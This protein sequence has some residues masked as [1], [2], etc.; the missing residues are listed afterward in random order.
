MSGRISSWSARHMHALLSSAG[1][2]VRSP[3]ATILTL[4]V[5]A[6]A[7]A[8]PLGL[9]TLVQ[10]TRSATGDFSGAIGM[11]VFLKSGVAEAKAQQL[12]GSLR[13][14]GDV[15]AA[16][17]ITAE[18][19]L[20][21]FRKDSGFGAALDALEENPLPHVIAVTPV[22][23]ATPAGIESLRRYLVSWPEV[24][25]VQLDSE[26]V[27][28]FNAILAV[29]R[30]VLL[31]AATLLGIG[32]IAIVGNTIR[33]EIL[34]RRAEIEVT[35]LVGGTNAFVRRP[36]LY[37]G[38]WYGLMAG[39]TAWLIV[40]GALWGLSGPAASLA[41]AYGSHFVLS[42]PTAAELGLLLLVGISLG[43]IG[44]WI[45]TAVHLQRIEP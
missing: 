35:K 34:N 24:E 32:V 8:M 36:F 43:W 39:L 45:A 28:R 30:R 13:A 29:L 27:T 40:A 23:S 6:L 11:S 33:L 17:L 10:N 31:V 14:R 12:T 38:M 2:L 42:P 5:M 26:W 4:L 3:L 44:S 15:S 7:L 22:S 16:E 18:Q 19:A 9:L 21:E 25:T 20:A 37:T 41:S 1:H